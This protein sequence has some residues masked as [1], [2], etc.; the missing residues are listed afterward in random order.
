[1]WTLAYSAGYGTATEPLKAEPDTFSVRITRSG[2]SWDG[3]PN[4]TNAKTADGINSEP[5]RATLSIFTKVGWS[6]VSLSPTSV[7]SQNE[8]MSTSVS[9]VGSLD[10]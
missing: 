5:D 8:A 10:K 7:S 9:Q 1:M 3:N 2:P 6:K 4:T